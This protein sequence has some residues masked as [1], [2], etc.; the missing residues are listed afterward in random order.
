MSIKYEYKIIIIKN[1]VLYYNSS[2]L[3]VIL[4]KTP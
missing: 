2:K 3:N 4:I 1:L